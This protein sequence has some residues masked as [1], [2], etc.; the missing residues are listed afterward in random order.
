MYAID[1]GSVSRHVQQ[2]VDLGLIARQP[3][4]QDRR[5]QL[6]SATDLGR[7]RIAEIAGARRGRFQDRMADWSDEDIAH[8]ASLLARYNTTQG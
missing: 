4:P 1:K 7:K 2:L 3:D 6:L 8:L 5:A